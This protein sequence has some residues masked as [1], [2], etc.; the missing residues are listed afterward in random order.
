[1]TTT[2]RPAMAA[3]HIWMTATSGATKPASGITL[4]PITA[5]VSTRSITLP[6]IWISITILAYPSAAAGSMA[7]PLPAVMAVVFT[8][9]DSTV[10]LRNT[11]IE[12]NTAVLG[13]GIYAS[14]SALY[15]YN[16]VFAGNNATSTAGDGIRL[17]TRQ[18]HSTGRTTP[19]PITTPAMAS[20]GRAI[21]V[22][23][24][25]Y[26]PGVLHHL[27]ACHQHQHNRPYG[28][29]FRYPRRLCGRWQPCAESAVCLHRLPRLP[30]AEHQ[31]GH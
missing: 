17:Y 24:Q 13:G 25:H 2:P 12:L 30:L 10:D 20:T 23:D 7:I 9:V 22:V 14:G 4:Q 11:F 31:P 15:L 6:W 5:V 16:D 8:A 21:D 3:V 27:G 28:H 1:M 18:A 29:L 19:W 26:E